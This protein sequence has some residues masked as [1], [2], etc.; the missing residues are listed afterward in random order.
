MLSVLL[1]TAASNCRARR[2]R[3]RQ[4][5]GKTFSC[6]FFF[7][8]AISFS[9]IVV[10]YISF[11]LWTNTHIYIYMHA[12]F[13][14]FILNCKERESD[15]KI[16]SYKYLQ[17]PN[18]ILYITLQLLHNDDQHIHTHTRELNLLRVCINQNAL[19]EYSLNGERKGR[20]K[21]YANCKRKRNSYFQEC[22]IW[23]KK[24][25]SL[26]VSITVKFINLRRK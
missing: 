9:P 19:K 11:Y 13:T 14:Q 1:I 4:D 26:L 16:P 15:G 25:L 24:Y 2:L 8:R 10:F 6:S 3:R 5:R 12:C 23:L 7:P 17:L 20:Q 22:V 21:V 18:V